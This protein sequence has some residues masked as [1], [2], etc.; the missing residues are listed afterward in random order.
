MYIPQEMEAEIDDEGNLSYLTSSPIEPP[1]SLK[2]KVRVPEIRVS[3][4]LHSAGSEALAEYVGETKLK[5]P[6]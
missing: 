2:M 4:K 6:A 3:L 5:W 1:T